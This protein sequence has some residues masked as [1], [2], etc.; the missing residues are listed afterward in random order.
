MSEGAGVGRRLILWSRDLRTRCSDVFEDLVFC[1]CCCLFFCHCL[2]FLVRSCLLITL[3]K[4]QMSQRSQVSRVTLL[5]QNQKW[6][7]QSVSQWVSDKV[8]YWAVRLSSG[9]LKRSYLEAKEVRLVIE[10]KRSDGQWRFACGD[11]LQWIALQVD[12]Q[13]SRRSWQAMQQI[14][15]RILTPL[16]DSSEW[17]DGINAC[18]DPFLQAWI[19][20]L[21][22]ISDSSQDEPNN[23]NC[24]Y[25]LLYRVSWF[26]LYSYCYCLYSYC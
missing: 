19:S 8:T 5:F 4:C 3:I 20:R 13:T 11:V 18:H 15:A 1:I 17:F 25:L 7:S 21:L 2:F 22:F 16:C 23:S 10:V 12:L 24:C 26:L 6:L 14:F 9:Q